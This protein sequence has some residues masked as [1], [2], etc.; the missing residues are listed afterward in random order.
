MKT[1][2]DRADLAAWI[3]AMDSGD[4]RLAALDT[5]RRGEVTG[6]PDEP[7]LSLRELAAVLGF[8]SYT[9]LHKLRIQSVG[10]R[11]GGGRLRYSRSR[12]EAYLRSDECLAVRAE[13]RQ[14]RRIAEHRSSGK[15]FQKI[16]HSLGAQNANIQQ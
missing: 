6:S 12:A 10:E 3:L 8:K 9:A 15:H 4:S 2:P 11:L 13:L 14:K 5:L 1:H 16:S 7:L